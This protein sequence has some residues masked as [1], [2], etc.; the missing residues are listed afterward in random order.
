MIRASRLL[1]F[2]CLSCLARGEEVGRSRCSFVCVQDESWLASAGVLPGLG[3]LGGSLAMSGL[4]SV[5]ADTIASL[6]GSKM[7]GSNS[8]F[9]WVVSPLVTIA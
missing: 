6:G 9:E 2:R 4:A 3:A 5:E 7:V 8:E 1:D